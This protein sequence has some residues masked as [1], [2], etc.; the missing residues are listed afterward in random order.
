MSA[1]VSRT[2]VWMVMFS[3]MVL[4]GAMGFAFLVLPDLQGVQIHVPPLFYLNT[5]VLAA[6]SALMHIAWKH[7]EQHEA[8]WLIMTLATGAAFFVLQGLAWVQLYTGGLSPSRSGPKVTFLYLLSLLHCL[9]L[10]AAMILVAMV[11]RGQIRAQHRYFEPAMYFWHFLGI[12][13]VY[14]LLVLTIG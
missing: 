8:R 10:V 2:S 12:L 4:F 11:L 14:L 13:W 7:R 9:H 1:S 3:V 6:S 5:L